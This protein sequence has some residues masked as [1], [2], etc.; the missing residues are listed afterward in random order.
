MSFWSRISNAVDGG[1]LHREIEEEF[2]SH[3]EEAIA[4]G[5]DP[6]EARRAFGSA[7]HAREASHGIRAA[8]WLESMLADVRFGWRQLG[9]SKVASASAVL[10]R[11]AFSTT[12]A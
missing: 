4:S 10:S 1:R 9:R 2:E 5:R 6:G 7:P 3:I 8:G 11:R 12:S